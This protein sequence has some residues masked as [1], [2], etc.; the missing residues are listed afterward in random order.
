MQACPV[1]TQRP[2]PDGVTES[3]A[4]M[5]T[6]C[7]R[8]PSTRFVRCVRMQSARGPALAADELSTTPPAAHKKN[9]SPITSLPSRIQDSKNSRFVRSVVFLTRA[10]HITSRLQPNNFG[11]ARDRERT[12]EKQ[13]CCF[14]KALRTRHTLNSLSK[15]NIS[16]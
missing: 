4:A 11:T 5:A 7:G 1:S 10:A 3:E 8:R 14:A 6:L 13:R 16:I 15:R 12:Q 9:S 2:P